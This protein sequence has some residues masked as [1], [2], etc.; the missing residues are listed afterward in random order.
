MSERIYIPV[1]EPWLTLFEIIT[2]DSENPTDCIR[3][4]ECG[5]LV[6]RGTTCLERCEPISHQSI[7]FLIGGKVSQAGCSDDTRNV[8]SRHGDNAHYKQVRSEQ[9]APTSVREHGYALFLNRMQIH[10]M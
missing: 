8:P 6:G 10:L 3:S 5:G 4:R 1:V 7:P 9:A 2:R